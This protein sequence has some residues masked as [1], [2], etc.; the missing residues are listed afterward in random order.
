MG[1]FGALDPARFAPRRFC[2][3]GGHGRPS[4]HTGRYW[5]AHFA[6]YFRFYAGAC[7]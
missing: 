3:V 6:Q 7:S 2:P 4:A 1:G 5:D